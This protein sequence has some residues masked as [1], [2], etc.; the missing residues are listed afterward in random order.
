MW[1][2][3]RHSVWRKMRQLDFESIIHFFVTNA[4]ILLPALLFFLALIFALIHWRERCL[5]KQM[6]GFLSPNHLDILIKQEKL[7]KA[8]RGN[9]EISHQAV[10]NV[11]A[12]SALDVELEMLKREMDA[13]LKARK[14]N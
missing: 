4:Q 12:Q 5:I 11:P 13:R 3:S 6:E 2:W 10:K 9:I 1:I 7:T 8:P 14:K